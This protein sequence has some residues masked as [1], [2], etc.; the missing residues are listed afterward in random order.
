MPLLEREKQ[1]NKI[2]RRRQCTLPLVLSWNGSH[3][4]IEIVCMCACHTWKWVHVIPGRVWPTFIHTVSF[5]NKE[6]DLGMEQCKDSWYVIRNCWKCPKLWS[7]SGTP[8]IQAFTL[9][10]S[11]VRIVTL[12]RLHVWVFFQIDYLI[13][14]AHVHWGCKNP[15]S[16][17][18]HIHC[19]FKSFS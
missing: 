7:F 12:S 10:Q 11:L 15:W 4:E 17:C 5:S 18:D 8:K 16:S 2:L 19:S 9:W 3:P 13:L 6:W 14:F 1:I